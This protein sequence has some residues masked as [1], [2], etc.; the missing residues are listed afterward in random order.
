MESLAALHNPDMIAGGLDTFD[1]NSAISMGD[2]SVNS[3]I[4]AQWQG[5]IGE[6]DA[7]ACKAKKEGKGHEKMN[8]ELSMCPK[9]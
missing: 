6:L 3:S 5:R 4:G 2:K 1:K 8:A 9:T 7:E